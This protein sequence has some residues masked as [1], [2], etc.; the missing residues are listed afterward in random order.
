MTTSFTN[1]R[2]SPNRC[3]VNKKILMSP[4]TSDAKERRAELTVIYC[5]SHGFNFY[6]YPLSSRFQ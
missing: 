3:I 5:L 4:L 2:Q 6:Y 1:W